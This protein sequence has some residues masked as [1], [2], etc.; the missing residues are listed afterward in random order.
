MGQLISLCN[1]VVHKWIGTEHWRSDPDWGKA[2]YWRKAY[3]S[4]TL[5]KTNPTYTDLELNMGLH[6]KREV[7]NRQRKHGNSISITGRRW[8]IWT[9]TSRI[10]KER[11]HY[12]WCIL[13]PGIDHR[14]RGAYLVAVHIELS[15]LQI[16]LKVYVV[17]QLSFRCMLA[18]LL[19]LSCI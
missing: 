7:T 10:Q 1:V 3:R 14:S 12:R 13:V 18:L 19:V 9:R 16:R 4:A 11:L 8:E 17:I 5:C 15:L 2:K 6:V